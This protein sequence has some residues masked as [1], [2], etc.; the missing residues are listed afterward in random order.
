[1]QSTSLTEF[2]GT[3]LAAVVFTVDAVFAGAAA[4]ADAAELA[5]GA[6]VATGPASV[7]WQAMA[8]PTAGASS[9]QRFRIW[10]SLSLA[11]AAEAESRSSPTGT[12][13]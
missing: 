11:R 10:R 6:A 8:A 5:V 4:L 1:L 2:A 9:A 13:L 3:D 7:S 12:P